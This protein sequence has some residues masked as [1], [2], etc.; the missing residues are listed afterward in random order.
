M[1]YIDKTVM[2]S[3]LRLLNQAFSVTTQIA[4]YF[5]Q[6][7]GESAEFIGINEHFQTAIGQNRG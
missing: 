1:Q 7:Q 6:E 2:Y 4:L 3:F 5:A